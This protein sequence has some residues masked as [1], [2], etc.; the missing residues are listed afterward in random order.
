[1][2]DFEIWMTVLGV[3][4]LIK[5]LV[6]ILWLCHCHRQKKI[7]EQKRLQLEEENRRR[8]APHPGHH[9]VIVDAAAPSA[10]WDRPPT[11]VAATTIQL[12]QHP[13]PTSFSNVQIEKP[14][15]KY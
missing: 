3:L 13:A 15:M 11:Y 4:L 9:V 6:G 5:V 12:Q 7:R 2:D 14:D 10:A 8:G 1:M